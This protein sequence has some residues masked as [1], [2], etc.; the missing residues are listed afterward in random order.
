MQIGG[1]EEPIRYSIRSLFL[2]NLVLRDA[3]SKPSSRVPLANVARFIVLIAAVL[4]VVM[5]LFPPFVS[6]TGT[7][8]AFLI[9]G[10]EWSRRI[11]S[12]VEDLGLKARIHWVL[13][14]VQIAAV[15][16]IAIG[17]RLLLVRPAA[18]LTII[19]M[20]FVALHLGASS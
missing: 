19:T 6:L 10:P 8:Y 14:A 1:G 2:A 18:P 7:E 9:D 15:W 5:L 17:A 12:V 20:T 16:A 13:L 3:M 11:G 4:T